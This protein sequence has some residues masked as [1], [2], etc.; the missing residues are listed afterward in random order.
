MTDPPRHRH[1]P[2]RMARMLGAGLLAALLLGVGGFLGWLALETQTRF[3]ELRTAGLD[4]MQWSAS[5]LEVDVLRLLNEAQALLLDPGASL[6]PLRTRFD[7]LYSRDQIITRGVITRELEPAPE[8]IEGLA[9]LR[10]F[11]D[12]N[13]P[14]IDGP[15]TPCAPACP[16]CWSRCRRCMPPPGSWCCAR[17]KVSRP[18]P[19]RSA[20]RWPSF[21]AALPSQR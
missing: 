16:R 18:R 19:T 11:L 4:N 17:S 5:Q 15:T 3:R 9:V 14:L 10:D 1:V 13:I 21:C 2:Q 12:R 6:A 8:V 7:V 20:P